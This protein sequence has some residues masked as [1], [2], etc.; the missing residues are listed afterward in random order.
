MIDII[1]TIDDALVAAFARL[2]PQLSKS[3]PPDRAALAAI[4]AQPGTRLLVFRDGGEILGTLTLTLYRIPTGLQAR[5][6]DVVVD[7]AARGKGAGEALSR[8]AIELAREAG[9]KNVTLTSRPSREGANR[10]YQRIGFIPIETNVYRLPL[11]HD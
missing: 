9:A 11:C 5:I 4:I 7:E 1:T 3:S 2:Q 6:D 10:L 8:K